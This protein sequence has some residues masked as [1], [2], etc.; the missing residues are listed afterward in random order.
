MRP[1][2]G[3]DDSLIGS[4]DWLNF[5]GNLQAYLAQNWW[6]RYEDCTSLPTEADIEK[7]EVT[8]RGVVLSGALGSL[9]PVE[10]LAVGGAAPAQAATPTAPMWG[11]DEAS[12]PAKQGDEAKARPTTGA[13][14]GLASGSGLSGARAASPPAGKAASLASESAELVPVPDLAAGSAGPAEVA[15]P[16]APIRDGDEALETQG[17]EAPSASLLEKQGDESE[18]AKEKMEGC[19]RKARRKGRRSA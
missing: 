16:T 19:S 8:L 1:S 9:V 18:R 11:S 15:T 13:S 3:P 5:F 12:L 17:D 14:M 7:L 10:E 4:R 6:P 2:V